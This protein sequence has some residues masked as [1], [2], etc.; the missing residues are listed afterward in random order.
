MEVGRSQLIMMS[1]STARRKVCS[2]ARS[3]KL[4]LSFPAVPAE[5]SQPLHQACCGGPA[6]SAV[7]VQAHVPLLGSSAATMATGACAGNAQHSICN[8]SLLPCKQSEVADGRRGAW[9]IGQQCLHG[10]HG[11]GDASYGYADNIPASMSL[12]PGLADTPHI[13]WLSL[14]VSRTTQQYRQNCAPFHV[15][16]ALHCRKFAF[17]SSATA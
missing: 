7:A 2:Q 6:F 8:Q 5:R 16:L 1:S 9:Q 14:S 15:L 3:R 11:S 13:V 4:L 17:E 10:K 12:L